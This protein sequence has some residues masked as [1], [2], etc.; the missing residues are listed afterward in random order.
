M[1]ESGNLYIYV[2]CGFIGTHPLVSSWQKLRNA[3]MPNLIY[4]HV[5]KRKNNQ[6]NVISGK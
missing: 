4:L 1:D 2:L 5:C 6:L 3:A